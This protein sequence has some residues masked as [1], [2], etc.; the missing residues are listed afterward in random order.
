MIIDDPKDDYIRTVENTCIPMIY[1]FDRL[2]YVFKDVDDNI[3]HLNGKFEL[4]LT[5]E[6]V[7]D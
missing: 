2:M 6:D 3:I 5:L 1:R 7:C 4:Q